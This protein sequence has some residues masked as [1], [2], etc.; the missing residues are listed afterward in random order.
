MGRRRG[1]AQKSSGTES[2]EGAEAEETKRGGK[3]LGRKAGP[4]DESLALY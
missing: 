3:G 1:L 4:R 2:R